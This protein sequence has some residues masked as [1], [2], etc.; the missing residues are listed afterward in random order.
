MTVE[1]PSSKA[2]STAPP[3][4]Y[5]G[6]MQ[7]RTNPT[8]DCKPTQI[9][10]PQRRP[11]N[12]TWGK[13]ESINLD[14]RNHNIQGWLLYPAN[15]DPKKN[16]DDHHVHGGP[17]QQDAAL[18][19]CGYGGVPFSALGYFVFMPNPRGSYGQAKQFMQ[20]NLKGLRLRRSEGL[21]AGVI[22]SRSAFPSTISA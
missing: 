19:V 16:T 18:A 11:A 2:P 4:V 8:P 13:T 14:Q 10:A 22:P 12:P 9:H 7:G 17:R 20:A 6:C 5:A 21:L 1:S 3:E 15:Y